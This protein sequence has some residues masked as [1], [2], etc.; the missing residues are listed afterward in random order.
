MYKSCK[1]GI[2]EEGNGKDSIK[3]QD[4]EGLSSTGRHEHDAWFVPRGRNKCPVI[5]NIEEAIH[6]NLRSGLVGWVWY[7]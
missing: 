1:C 4:P 7:C 3:P 2:Q 6:N 5:E